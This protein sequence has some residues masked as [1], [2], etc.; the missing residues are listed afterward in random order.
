MLFLTAVTL[1]LTAAMLRSAFAMALVAVLVMAAFGA[2][3]LMGP[4]S[5]LDLAIGLVGYNLGIFGMVV[6]M[7]VFS[8]KTV[9]A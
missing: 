4:V 2:A 6:G 7:V 5:L 3:A 9:A 8:R 1:G